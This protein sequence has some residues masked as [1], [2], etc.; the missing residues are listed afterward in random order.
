MATMSDSTSDALFGVDGTQSPELLSDPPTGLGSGFW[1]DAPVLPPISLLPVPDDSA[2]R[3][4][5]A[6]ALGDDP[7]ATAEPADQDSAAVPAPRTAEEP[8]APAADAPTA[9][10]AAAP[11]PGASAGSWAG[12][13][14]PTESGDRSSA[15]RPQVSGPTPPAP[16]QPSRPAGARYRPPM[17]ETSG[18]RAPL[19]DRRLRS[20]RERVDLPLRAGSN[21]GAT[22]FFSTIVIIMVLLLYFIIAGLMDSISSFLP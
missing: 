9:K 21:G 4:A 14:A 18:E 19:T 13:P 10:V 16:S 8:K 3:K 15:R 12:R 20:R 5:I 6:A 22:A 2:L 7:D 17:A 11:H 1:R